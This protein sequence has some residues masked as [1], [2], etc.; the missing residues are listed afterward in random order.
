M[1]KLLR[2][3]SPAMVVACLAL[4]VALGGTSIAAVNQLAEK[5]RRARP[6]PVRRGDESEDQRQ[7][8]QLGEGCESLAAALGLRAGPASGRADGPAGASRASRCRGRRGARPGDDRCDHGPPQSVVDRRAESAENGACNTAVIRR[9]AQ[10]N[11]RAISGGT[12]MERRNP[13]LELVT[14]RARAGLERASQVVG[15]L[16]DWR[17]RQRASEHVHR[18]RRS[19]TR[20]ERAC[21]A[22]GAETFTPCD[23]S[24][25]TLARVLARAVT[26]ALVG[27]EPRKVEV[28]AHLQPGIPGFAIVGLADRACQE[29]KHRVRSGVVSASLEWPLNRRITVN[30]APAALRKEGSGFDLPISLARA[31]RDAAASTRAAGRARGGR[32]A[33]ARRAN[34]P[35]VRDACGSRRSACA[36]GCA[37]RLRRG[38]GA[39]GR[40][41]GHRAGSRSASCRGRRVLSGRDRRAA[42]RAPL[43]RRR[44]TAPRRPTWRTFAARSEHAGP[45]RSRP[46]ARTT[47]CLRDRPA[48]GRRCLRG[49]SRGFFRL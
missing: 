45:S 20:P 37:S 33:R 38:V 2:R 1:R 32:R 49:A 31:G 40:A 13:G 42:V 36:R 8:R 48:P 43:G 7:R 25:P 46:R 34:S 3:P 29:A 35:G 5:Q 12:A 15:F 23:V 26:H 30:L 4:L 28:E 21:S 24:A 47:C 41:R 9:S 14:G 19:A 27:L 10:G 18:A 17:K 44:S 6:A 22:F 11:E 16:G 39:G